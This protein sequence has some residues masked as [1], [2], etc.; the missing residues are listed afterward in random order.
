MDGEWNDTRRSN[1]AKMTAMAIIMP[2]A[3]AA[4]WRDIMTFSSVRD[5]SLLF[6]YLLNGID[7]PPFRQTSRNAEFE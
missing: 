2:T 7:R 5:P 6:D 4:I 1:V 3:T